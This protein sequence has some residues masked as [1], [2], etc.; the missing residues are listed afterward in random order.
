MLRPAEPHQP[1]PEWSTSQA[2]SRDPQRRNG[3]PLRS[4]CFMWRSWDTHPGLRDPKAWACRSKKEA[5]SSPQSDGLQPAGDRGQ[6]PSL[7]W[8]LR[9]PSLMPRGVGWLGRWAAPGAQAR[10][11]GLT[12][13]LLFHLLHNSLLGLM[14]GDAKSP[15]SN[16]SECSNDRADVALLIMSRALSENASPEELNGTAGRPWLCLYAVPSAGAKA[17]PPPP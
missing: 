7:L 2:V 15:F 9:S 13:H 17:E 8:A 16:G 4:D 10:K 6:G 14:T 5:E 11:R 1:G 3:G 12:P